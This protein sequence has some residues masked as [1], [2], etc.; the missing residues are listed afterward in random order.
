MNIDGSKIIFG[1]GV[2]SAHPAAPGWAAR[3]AR[4]AAP[5]AP[6]RAQPA[7]AARA[8]P[9]TRLAPASEVPENGF[10]IPDGIFIAPPS[11]SN[12]IHL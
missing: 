12:H 10:V 6:A 2:T 1:L 4:W 5:A 8:A 11:D 7:A 3:P 9:P